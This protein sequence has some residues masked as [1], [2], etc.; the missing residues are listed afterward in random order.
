MSVIEPQS[1]FEAIAEIVSLAAATGAQMHIVHLN[2]T[3]TRDIPR[4][5]ELLRGAQGRGLKITDRGVSVRAGF[6]VVGMELFR[7]NWKERRGG[8]MAGDIELAGVPFT[9]ET[10]AEAQAKAPGTWIVAHFMRP[11]CN[12]ADQALL[13]QSV[14]MPGGGDRV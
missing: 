5:A 9:D 11:D 4:I 14:L 8:A 12:P 6:T 13:D 2:S 7:G 10:L 1:S 3:S